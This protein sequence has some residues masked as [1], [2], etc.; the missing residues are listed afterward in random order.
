[1]PTL[2]NNAL[3]GSIINV[4]GVAGGLAQ[5]TGLLSLL[6]NQPSR[7]QFIKAPLGTVLYFDAVLSETHQATSLPTM[8]PVEDG[9]VISDHVIQNPITLSLTGI[10]S[11]TPLPDTVSGQL[12][13][14]LG[15]AATT[16]LPPLGVTLA[17]TAFAIYQ[18]GEDK[19]K[20]SKEAYGILMSLMTGNRSANPPTP[21]EPFTV[22]TKYARYPD[23]IITNLTFPVDASTDG[24]LVFT[25][26]LMRMV[27]V[28]PQ[29]VNLRKLSNA[30][31][32]AAR[33]DAGAQDA[34]SNEIVDAAKAGF[35]STYD[36]IANVGDRLLGVTGG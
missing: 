1:M 25:V 16:L 7:V 18:T 8:F 6:E 28:T 20:R 29:V 11:D 12:T 33:V 24:Q 19:M 22:L 35:K 17:S 4:T 10:I 5:S 15:A 30:V 9:S 14:T 3:N 13:Q 27:R 31:L 21:P 2:S 32:A 36:P 26:D 23:M 34:E